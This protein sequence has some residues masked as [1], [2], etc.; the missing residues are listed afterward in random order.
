[1]LFRSQRLARPGWTVV[2]VGA[3]AGYHSLLAADLGGEGSQIVAFEPGAR[4]RELLRRSLALNADRSVELVAAACWDED[5]MVSFSVSDDPRNTGLSST[6]AQFADAGGAAVP[7]VRLDRWCAERALRP[8][9][10]KIDVEGAELHVLRGAEGLLR[11]A[12]PAHIVCELWPASRAAAV[13]LMSAHGYRAHGIASDGSLTAS[14]ED[15][16]AW[17]DVCFRHRSCA[18]P[19]GIMQ[20]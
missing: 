13:E 16:Q 12:P 18:D 15:S 4:M 3:N 9:L 5:A 6:S 10:V 14:P 20:T 7:G 19:P 2:D 8:E 17:V 11:G 1:M